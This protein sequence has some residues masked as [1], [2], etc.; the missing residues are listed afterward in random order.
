M[1]DRTGR[2]SSR[3]KAL[4]L[5]SSQAIADEAAQNV[6]AIGYYG[7]GYISPKVKV[8]KVAA[9]SGAPFMAPTIDDVQ[10]NAYPIARPLIMYTKGEPKDLAKTFLDYVLSARGTGD[11]EADRLC[12]GGE[13][14]TP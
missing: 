10:S 7:M 11:R 5:P 13:T 4:L 9:S 1:A 14:L 6:D 12:P 2:K 3:R 8:L